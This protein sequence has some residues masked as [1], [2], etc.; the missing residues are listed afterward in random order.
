MS[1][2]RPASPTR[3][4]SGFALR[5]KRRQA[6]IWSSGASSRAISLQLA[7]CMALHAADTAHC[8]RCSRCTRIAARSPPS[9]SSGARAEPWL[10][11]GGYPH[12]HTRRPVDRST[13]APLAACLRHRSRPIASAS[14]PETDKSDQVRSGSGQ[15]RFGSSQDGSI[16]EASRARASCG[17]GCWRWLNR[18]DGRSAENEKDQRAARQTR[19]GRAHR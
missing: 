16:A 3:I 14:H 11:A 8:P 19:C 6:L 5:A 9:R 15:V 17:G 12:A 13:E 10:A 1:Q 4:D 2:H 18:R 7:C